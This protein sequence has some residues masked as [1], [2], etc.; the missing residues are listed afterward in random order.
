MAMARPPPRVQ[1][2]DAHS[3]SLSHTHTHTLTLSFS[4]SWPMPLQNTR[5]DSLCSFPFLL[6]TIC[7]TRRSNDGV[8]P[9]E[10]EV[11][12]QDHHPPQQQHHSY[13]VPKTKDYGDFHQYLYSRPDP[14]ARPSCSTA[15]HEARRQR[16]CEQCAGGWE[17]EF[18]VPYPRRF[19]CC[20]SGSRRP[21][22]VCLA[23]R[24]C[25]ASLPLGAFGQAGGVV[26]LSFVR[27]GGA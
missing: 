11:R 5:T 6:Q 3:L 7:V 18:G 20:S 8:E 27:R 12:S 21:Y 13:L 9:S 10:D 14:L 1:N 22:H 26:E 17:R 4:L 2:H 25:A 15:C 23:P 24:M 19:R 16:H